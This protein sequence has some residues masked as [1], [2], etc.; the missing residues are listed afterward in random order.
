MTFGVPSEVLNR[1][2]KWREQ[3]DTIVFTSGVFEILHVGHIRLLNEA[4]KLGDRLVIAVNTD[5]SV[6]RKK[7]PKRPIN[8]LD[9]RLEFLQ[10][11]RAVDVAFPFDSANEH[12]INQIREIQPDIFAK[13]GVEWNEKN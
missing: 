10:N 12:P 8:P 2:Q 4:S 9:R 5:D 7:G 1:I 11:L 6:K 3:G 13:S